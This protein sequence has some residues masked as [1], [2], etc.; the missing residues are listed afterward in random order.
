MKYVYIHYPMGEK[1]KTPLLTLACLA[2]VFC[3]A[4]AI[5]HEVTAPASVAADGAGHFSFTVLV[6]VTVATA[7]GSA[8]INGTD[9]TNL[10]ETFLDGFCITTLDPGFYPWEITGDL[11][12]PGLGGS[13]LYDHSLCDGWSGSVTVNIIPPAVAVEKLTWST[14][15]ALYR[16]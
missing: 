13:V 16:Q 7:Q 12:D 10:G 8:Y 6:E 3:S 9:N 14:L 1:M 2:L 5:A 15:K 11:T 4:T